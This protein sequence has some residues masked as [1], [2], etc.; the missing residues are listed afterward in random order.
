ME[1][2]SKHRLPVLKRLEGKSRRQQTEVDQR[3]YLKSKLYLHEEDTEEDTERII[4]F[5][6]P[7][8]LWETP[9]KK[10]P[11]LIKANEN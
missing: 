8:I 7:Q 11:R 9:C 6:K 1:C 3:S 2:Q 4:N 5:D 10:L